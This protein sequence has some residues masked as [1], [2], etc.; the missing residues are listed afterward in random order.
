M[1]SNYAHHRFGCLGLQTLSSEHQRQIGRFR[2]LYDVGQHGPDPLFYY[3]PFWKNPMYHLA[4]TFHGQSGQ[5]FFT[6]ACEAWKAAPSEAGRVYLYG[7]LGHYCLDSACHP[8][9]HE[10]QDSGKIRHVELETDFERFLL[11]RDGK[12]PP[13][14]QRVTGHVRLTRGE[15]V[16]AAQFF[17]GTTPNQINRSIRNMARYSKLLVRKNRTLLEAVTQ[18]AG[19]NL[20]DHVMGTKPNPRCESMHPQLLE[21][22]DQALGRYAEMIARLDDHLN[23]GTPLGELFEPTFG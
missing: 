12:V 8:F 23:H 22:F 3:N 15:C 14:L 13:H 1:P 10:M 7:L 17:P 21:H 6:N 9:V 19:D 18:L 2:Q 5:E 16:T 4:K 20:R 11:R